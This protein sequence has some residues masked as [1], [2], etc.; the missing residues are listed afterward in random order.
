MSEENAAYQTRSARAVAAGKKPALQD[1]LAD[2]AD[3]YAQLRRDEEKR[4]AG[5]MREYDRDEEERKS[6]IRERY[7]RDCE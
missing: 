3:H 2:L 5:Q 4:H 6:E 1:R 7:A